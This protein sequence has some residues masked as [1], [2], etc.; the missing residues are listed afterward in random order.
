MQDVPGSLFFHTYRLI[1]GLSAP[2]LRSLLNRRLI[3]GKE[4]ADRVREKRGEITV[5]RPDGPLVWIHAASVGEVQSALI[6]IRRLSAACPAIHILVTTGTVT[7]ARIVEGKLPAGAVHQFCPLD[8]PRW[9]EAFLDHW[10]PDLVFWMESELWPNLLEGLRTR[11]VPAVLVNARLSPRSF[12]AWQWA[13]P[14]AARILGA[15]RLV[16][17]QTDEDA[18]RLR[19]LG[20]SGRLAV[21]DNLKYSAL[22]LPCDAGT[23]EDFKRATAGRAVWVF[24]S[25]HKGEEAMAARV[26]SV[27][28]NRVP[29]LL[30]IIV[31]RHPERRADIADTLRDC[32]LGVR[33]R[34]VQADLPHDEDDL[35]IADTLGELGLFYRLCP[36]ACIGRSFSDDGGGGHNPLEAAQ[37]NCAVLH[38]PNIQNLQQIYD[39]MGRDGAAVR[40]AD[41]GAL[42]AALADLFTNA[43]RMENQRSKGQS[44]AAEKSGVIDRVMAEIDPLLRVHLPE[45]R[46]EQAVRG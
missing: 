44:F 38:G 34:G 15:F 4:V 18:V 11:K 29:N 40:L 23:L 27:V 3:N 7:S 10:R 9:A 37:L 46:T 6:L 20:F 39:D 26:H 14:L 1:T 25:T 5:K 16:L 2:A 17:A 43:D 42:S 21:T 24:A 31:P 28:K 19:S 41:E 36:V 30:T 32:G 35:Y 33:F 13:K 8:H 45:A 12:R 22:P